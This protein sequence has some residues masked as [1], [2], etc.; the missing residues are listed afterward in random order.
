MLL[1]IVMLKQYWKP[2][3]KYDLQYPERQLEFIRRLEKA[4]VNGNPIIMLVT[5]KEN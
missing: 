2:N 1:D 4:N 5:P 3:T